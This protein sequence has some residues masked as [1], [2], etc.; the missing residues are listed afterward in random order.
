[1]EFPSGFRL[2]EVARDL[3]APGSI[4]FDSDGNLLVAETGLGGSEPRIIGFRSDGTEFTL[5]PPPRLAVPL[6]TLSTGFRMY[7]PIG[8]LVAHDG[9]VYVSHRDRQDLGVITALQYDGSHET[10]V[11]DLPAQGDFGVTDLAISP[12]GRLYFGVGSATNS[13]V[14]GV[15]NWNAGWVDNHR[16]V[17]DLSAVDLKLLG[18]RYDTANPAK[19]LFDWGEPELAV[20][21]PFQ[22]F[23]LARKLRI[24]RA[25]D[26]RPNSA[27]YSVSPLGGD[28]R[29]EAYGVRYPRGLAFN[30]FG[31]LFF[32]N[33][34]MEMR[35]TRPVANDPDSL[36][37]FVPGTW[38]G[39]PDFTTDLNS[40]TDPTFQPPS[41]L[42]SRY[43]YPENA[44]VIDPQASRLVRPERD[45]LLHV[46][47]PVQS[48]AAKFTF[49]PPTGMF[50]DFRGS[51]IVALSGDR[52]R[53]DT[54]TDE[55]P[56]PAGTELPRPGYRVVQ[57]T[58]N[59]QV[60]DLVYN[61]R[62]G[63]ISARDDVRPNFFARLTGAGLPLGLERPADVK[64]GPDGA[65]YI[66]D[67]GQ[68]DWHDGKPRVRARTGRIWRLTRL[69]TGSWSARA[70][71][72][73]PETPPPNQ[74]P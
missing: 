47:L 13:G 40:V 49:V 60:R 41:E 18:Y 74:A 64:F 68:I 3:T 15:D 56:K 29:V 28:T 23:G 61:V 71:A 33:N 51:A 69:P 19:G 39:W 9:R 20:T 55:T 53:F 37:K 59:R 21:A 62:P 1:M 46:A 34:G 38:Y 70:P 26:G 43:G 35:G 22:P 52:G 63:P 17:C 24:S 32:T 6:T 12:P 48:G 65:L 7:G 50:Q 57:V 58:E 14:V 67:L 31:R 44:A 36:L 5:Y 30:E 72:T 66:A 45:A 54:A 42:V 11:A 16:N 10:V 25:P 4:F 2:E 27:I 8:G 73:I